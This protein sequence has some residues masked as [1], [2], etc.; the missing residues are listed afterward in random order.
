M[1]KKATC[2]LPRKMLDTAKL[3]QASDR[4]TPNGGN[5]LV[6]SVPT[7]EDRMHLGADINDDSI[8]PTI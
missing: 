8:A 6:K 4:N 5:D 7:T 2:S 3:K 1:I